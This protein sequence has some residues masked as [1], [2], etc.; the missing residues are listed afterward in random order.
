MSPHRRSPKLSLLLNTSIVFYANH[1]IIE[2]QV[3]RRALPVWLALTVHIQRFL[4]SP[5]VTEILSKQPTTASRWLVGQAVFDRIVMTDGPIR[6]TLDQA[7]ACADLLACVVM[8]DR[9][10]SLLKPWKRSLLKIWAKVARYG[11]EPLPIIK[12]R[13]KASVAIRAYKQIRNRIRKHTPWLTLEEAHKYLLILIKYKGVN[14]DVVALKARLDAISRMYRL[15]LY[16][17]RVKPAWSST[18]RP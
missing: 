4:N 8:T 10:V 1:K 18:R 2:L 5:K 17:R 9:G 6:I 14:R 16:P 7:D 11:F 15:A 13:G 12:L 3:S